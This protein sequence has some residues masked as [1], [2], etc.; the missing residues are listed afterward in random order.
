[1]DSEVDS[2]KYYSENDLTHRKCLQC[3]VYSNIL[4]KTEEIERETKL[5]LRSME[6][7]YQNVRISLHVS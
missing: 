3:E 1:M 2:K 5:L 7:T 4:D 6:Y